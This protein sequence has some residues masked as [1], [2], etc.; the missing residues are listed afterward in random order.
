[1]DLSALHRVYFIGIG[2]IGMSALARYFMHHGCLVAGYDRTAGEVTD[3][4]IA[5]GAD[6]HFTDSPELVPADTELVIYT[7]AIPANHRELNHLRAAGYP[8]RKRSEVLGLIADKGYTIAVAGTH[9]KTTISAMS[10]WL[11]QVGGQPASAF[12][13]GIANNWQS[14]FVP[15]NSGRVVVEADE[16]DRS[17]LRLFPDVAV[18]SAMDADHLDVYGDTATMEEGFLAFCAQIKAGGTLIARYDLPV[19]A[20]M[21][22]NRQVITYGLH[23]EADLSAQHIRVEEGTF[24][25]DVRWQ[26]QLIT[27]F[28]L[29]FPGFHNVE[30]AL[31]AMA[32]GLT[33]GCSWADMQEALRTFT[34]IRRRMEI[35]Y[36]SAHQVVID[37]YAHHPKELEALIRSAKALFPGKMVSI[38]FQPHLYSRTR[39]LAE[40]FAAA[41]S[42]ADQVYLLPIYP[43]REIPI[44]GVESNLIQ[45][46]MTGKSVDIIQKSDLV[47]TLMSAQWEVL[48]MAGAGD[49]D[50]LVA[51]LVHALKIEKP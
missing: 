24:R 26:G 12:L 27:G 13:G 15:A 51:P 38:V 7:P 19:V 50:R 37:D 6:I 10:A 31:A 49:I 47:D 48:L 8:I 16:Y 4:L 5:A 17:F 32:V 22:P 23:D 20:L 11:L 18:V 45:E 46:K 1:M 44:P 21:R 39:D 33:Q 3:A 28:Q 41:L 14:N 35:A 30:N 34:G 42:M 29:P 43:A 9:G 40:G 25:F 2:G 36:R